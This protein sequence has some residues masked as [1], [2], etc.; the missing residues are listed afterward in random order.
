MVR[1]SEHYC[2]R[3]RQHEALLNGEASL[4]R[5]QFPRHAVFQVVNSRAP[6][7]AFRWT[8]ARLFWRLGRVAEPSTSL[9]S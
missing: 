1:F 8:A 5:R 3:E 4:S 6:K 2:I 7:R 9:R